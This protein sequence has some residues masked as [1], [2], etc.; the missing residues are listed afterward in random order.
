MSNTIL[1][2]VLR[3]P[4]ELWLGN[5]LDQ[6]QRYARYMEAAEKVE[7]LEAV[8]SVVDEWRNGLEAD[9]AV[10]KIATIADGVLT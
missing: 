8:M 3:M 5:H 2:G 4:P 10:K 7:K 9:E 1:L 6:I